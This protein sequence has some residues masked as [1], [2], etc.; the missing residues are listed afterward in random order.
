MLHSRLEMGMYRML[1]QGRGGKIGK[2]ALSRSHGLGSKII[3][4]LEYHIIMKGNIK[5]NSISQEIVSHS[6]P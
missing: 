4:T 6:C 2:G 5:S 3:T 1:F